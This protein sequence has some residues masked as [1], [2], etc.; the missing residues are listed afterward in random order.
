MKHRSRL[1]FAI[2][3][4][5]GAALLAFALCTWPISRRWLDN[6]GA[7]TSELE[8]T[9]PGDSLV[10]HDRETHTRAI[11]IATSSGAVW[12]WIAQFG[13]GK[14]GFYSYELLER[15]V[16]IPVTNVE[17]I[18]PTMQSLAVGDEVLLHPKARAIPVGIVEHGRH[19]CFGA[20]PAPGLQESP[21]G[22]TRSWSFYVEPVTTESCRLIV[23]SCIE[24]DRHVSIL[25]RLLREVEHPVDFA[26]EQRMLRTVKRLAENCS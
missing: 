1:R 8:R 2:E 22:R 26:M 23:R 3:G 4:F 24:T 7:R 11:D 13:L 15:L 21:A 25:R 6:W 10:P 16:G 12:P 19:I 9:W 14:A 18:E 5:E 20:K 17:S